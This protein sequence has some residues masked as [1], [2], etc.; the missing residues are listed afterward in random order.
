MS[1][2]RNRDRDS[3]S[4]GWIAGLVGAGIGLLAGFIISKIAS[5]DSK[6]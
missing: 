6:K 3:N 2:N 4:S 5:N 1:H